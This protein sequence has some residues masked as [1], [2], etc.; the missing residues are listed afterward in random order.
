VT[1][2]STIQRRTLV[3][4]LFSL[5]GCTAIDD[6]VAPQPRSVSEMAFPVPDWLQPERGQHVETRGPDVERLS[7]IFGQVLS[8]SKIPDR[9]PIRSVI[10]SNELIAYAYIDGPL[11]VSK[12][13]LELCENDGQVAAIAAQRYRASMD[14]VTAQVS[15]AF[16]LPLNRYLPGDLW[17]SQMKQADTFAIAVLAKIGYD[18]R[19]VAA[20]WQRIGMSDENGRAGFDMRLR[21]IEDQLREL[22]YAA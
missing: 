15:P 3:A 1:L 19:D 8:I 7:R 17:L 5:G 13:V 6:G 2:V 11:F 4:G 20:I 10:T 9:N 22:G 12:P 14:F 18:P 16:K 21:A